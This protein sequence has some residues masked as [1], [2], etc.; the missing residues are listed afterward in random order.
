M[1]TSESQCDGKSLIRTLII[2]VA[3]AT[4]TDILIALRPNPLHLLNFIINL[5]PLLSKLFKGLFH[6]QLQQLEVG[7]PCL[8]ETCN[9]LRLFKPSVMR[10]IETNLSQPRPTPPGSQC[11]N[12]PPDIPRLGHLRLITIRDRPP[13]RPPAASHHLSTL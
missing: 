2:H 13:P 11:L 9:P 7:C 3:I 12:I 8:L 1:T 10:A 5:H 6:V 4:L